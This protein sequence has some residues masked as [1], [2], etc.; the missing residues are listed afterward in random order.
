MRHLRP[1]QG[2]KPLLAAH[3][4]EQS[5]YLICGN[6]RCYKNQEFTP[7]LTTQP[8]LRQVFLP[9]SSPNLNPMERLWKYLCQKI[10]NAPFY[11]T[12]GQ[13]RQAVLGFFSRLDEFGQG[14]T[15]LLTL[16]FHL[17]DSQPTSRG[18]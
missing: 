6:A 15:S 13:F 2:A 1:E 16:H 4:A 7:W 8:Q 14:L 5:I 3:P 17:L 11:R 12:K 10:I 18:V 9:P